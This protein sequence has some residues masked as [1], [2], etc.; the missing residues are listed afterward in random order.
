MRENSRASK[1]A[2]W[3]MALAVAACLLLSLRQPGAGQVTEV[4]YTSDAPITAADYESW[5]LFLV[6]NP[7][8]AL[9]QSQEQLWD[10]YKQF[11]AFGGVIGP[12][13]AAVWFSTREDLSDPHTALDAVRSSAFCSRLELSPTQGPYVV[14][15]TEYPGEGRVSAYPDTFNRPENFYV[16][17]LN[18]LEASEITEVLSRLAD[19]VVAQKIRETE[20]GS[21]DFWSKWQQAFAAV[22][23]H[24]SGLSRRVRVSIQTSFFSVEIE[25]GSE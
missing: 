21:E 15:T 10:L 3:P 6:C 23:G 4:L 20:P 7:Q 2:C 14:V 13:H 17:E 8:W 1:L 18:G 22:Q 9:P 19:Q 11:L 25:P 24:L 12:S 16:F 5:S